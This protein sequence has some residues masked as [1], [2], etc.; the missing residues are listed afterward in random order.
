[1]QST[2]Q[3]ARCDSG[4]PATREYQFMNTSVPDDQGTEIQP[5]NVIVRMPIAL[6]T[7]SRKQSVENLNQ[8]LADAMSLRDLYKKHHWQVSGATFLQMHELFDD[9]HSQQEDAIDAIA[10]RIQSRGG[11]SLA[12]AADVAETTRVPRPPKGRETLPVQIQRLLNAHELVLHEARAMAR[13]AT[14]YGDDGTADLLVS[15]VIRLNELQAWKLS[16]HLAPSS[17]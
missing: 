14:E 11:V 8:L 16:Q 2:A 12:M 9:H 17:E 6:A 15:T 7:S 13:L 4:I 10:E 3:R 1:M 5:F